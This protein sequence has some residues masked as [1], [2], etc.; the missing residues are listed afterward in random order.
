MLGIG[1]EQSRAYGCMRL[2]ITPW[3]LG[4]LVAKST[5]N[6]WSSG[7]SLRSYA[8]LFRRIPAINRKNMLPL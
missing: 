1:L 2:E 6:S 7:L 5:T 3:R 8:M 4:Y